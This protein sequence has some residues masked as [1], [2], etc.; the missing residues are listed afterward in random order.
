[1]KTHFRQQECEWSNQKNCENIEISLT[2]I[3]IRELALDVFYFDT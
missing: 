3:K 2:S 1:M